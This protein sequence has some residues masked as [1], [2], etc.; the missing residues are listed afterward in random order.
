MI[1][2][3]FV[4]KLK[5][6]SLKAALDDFVQ[7]IGRFTKVDVL[8]IK[9][10]PILKNAEHAAMLK[11]AER[12][13]SALKDEYAIVLD[14]KG[15]QLS[16][17]EFASLIKKTELDRKIAFIVGGP[18]GMHESVLARANMTVSFSRLTMGNQLFRVVLAE[19]VY[20]AYAIIHNTGYHK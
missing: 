8:E 20:R 14:V 7:R 9:D 10:E 17:E 16:S 4:G 5:D 13:L 18:C 15:K 6:A 2:L 19:Q 11:E 3:I 1:K 12:I